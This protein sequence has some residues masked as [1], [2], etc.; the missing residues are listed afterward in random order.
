MNITKALS[1]GMALFSGI[2]AL[3]F[4]INHQLIGVLLAFISSACL[5]IAL[6]QNNSH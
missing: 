1:F 2:C 5:V 3:P 6:V 4:L